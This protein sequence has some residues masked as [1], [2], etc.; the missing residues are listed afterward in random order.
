MVNKSKASSGL[1]KIYK[2]P[3][4]TR[5]RLK[6]RE[7]MSSLD[8]LADVTRKATMYRVIKYLLEDKPALELYMSGMADLLTK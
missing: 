8:S 7:A 1:N 2:K 3:L 4:A 6:I 5:Q